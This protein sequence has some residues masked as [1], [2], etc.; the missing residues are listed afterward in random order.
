MKN[1]QY[2]ILTV[3]AAAVLGISLAYA[4]PEAD[5]AAAPPAAAMV[6]HGWAERCSEA[7]KDDKKDKT[8]KY[9]EV[10]QRLDVKDTSTRVAEMV[11]GFPDGKDTARG[12]VI[13]P[14]G[15]LLGNN[16]GMKIDDGK[17]VVFDVRF[18]V[19]SGCVSYLNIN[20]TLL[21]EM[22]KGKSA[23]FSFKTAE[24]QDV[25]LLLSMDG[26]GKALKGIL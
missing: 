5:K 22:K 23:T 13:L 17:P 3:L 8:K 14:L 2:G 21:D 9:C 12:V 10:F 4:A 15:I 6:E 20:K 11:V 1:F 7:A 26:F 24:G 16:V 18:C 19:A 25:N